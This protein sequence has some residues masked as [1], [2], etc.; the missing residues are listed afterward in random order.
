MATKSV[1][2]IDDEIY[3][4]DMLKTDLEFE[5][6]TVYTAENGEKGLEQLQKHHPRVIILDLKMPIMNGIEFLHNLQPRINKTSSVIV[7]TGYGIDKDVQECYKLG[8]QSFLRK[9]VNMHELEALIKRNFEMIQYSEQLKHEIK[10]KNNANILLQNIF[11]GMAE[12][13]VALDNHFHIQMISQK[14][15][16]TLGINRKEALNKPAASVLGT[17]IAGSSGI[18]LKT[19]KQKEINDVHTN[20]LSPSGSMIPVKLSL[21]PLDEKETNL[22]YLLFFRNLKEEERVVRKTS[23]RVIFGKMLSSC[24][25]MKEVF[26]LIETISTS[27][28]TVLIQG[29]SG[30]GKELVARETHN[31]S[32]R[33]DKPMFTVNCAAIPP[34]LLESEFF[35]HE[36]GAFT[37]AHKTKKGR[38]ELAN[39]STLFL[40]EI[41]EIPVELQAKLLR[42]LQEQK[43]ERVGGTQS[44]KVDV[45]IITATNHDLDL[46][47]KEKRF[48]EDL[49]YRLDVIKII[50]PPLRKRMDDIPLLIS[51]FIKELNRKE[52]RQVK[53]V[54]SDALQHMYAYPWPGNIRELYHAIEHA[55]AV[56]RDNILKMNNFP[57]KLRTSQLPSNTKIAKP[58]NEKEAILFALEQSGFH[59]GKTA[60]LL[61][62]S[63]VTLYRKIKKYRIQV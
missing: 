35:G 29:E 40:D 9:P 7:L 36:K 49:F 11:N 2:V 39:K 12:G 38:F 37:G 14:A 15:C 60:A 47:V 30:T 50:L 25:N 4:R 31:R 13:I 28:A 44:I 20:L 42:V 16:Q 27:N 48:R 24:D 8:I 19:N 58:K 62:I 56:S 1:L 59:K 21:K 34:N 55:Y 43:F 32:T 52:N 61:G 57:Q 45:R 5:G 26:N 33:A 53:G 17:Q 23:G 51:Y 18:I 63:Y 6:Y 41:A 3:I 46:L 10:E 22:S 54:A